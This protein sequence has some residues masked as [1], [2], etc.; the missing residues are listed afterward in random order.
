LIKI[1]VHNWYNRNLSENQEIIFFDVKSAAFHIKKWTPS[2]CKGDTALN[3]EITYHEITGLQDDLLLPWLDLY[4]T[5]FPANEKVLVSHFLALLKMKGKGKQ[6]CDYMLAGMDAASHKLLGLACYQLMPA[7]GAAVLWYL[8]IHPEARNRGLGGE[9]YDH[10]I[11]QIDK[12]LYKALLLEVEIPTLQK[13]DEERKRAARRINFYRRHGAYLLEGVDYIQ[14]IGW[15]SPP[16]PMH[17]MVHPLQVL[18]APACFA[19]AKAYAGDAV[20]QAGRLKLT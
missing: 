14:Y 12:T 8:A 9:F 5:A 16:T 13:N 19:L 7:V 17:I 18:N 10:V 3:N 2:G 4:E 20:T 6:T 1:Q 15:H 11:D